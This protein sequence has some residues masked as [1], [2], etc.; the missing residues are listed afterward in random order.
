MTSTGLTRRVRRTRTTTSRASTASMLRRAARRSSRPSVRLTTCG[1]CSPVTAAASIAVA[2]ETNRPPNPGVKDERQLSVGRPQ[3]QLAGD[4]FVERVPGVQRG[5]G[6]V[7]RRAADGGVAGLD[8]D[9]A[10]R[11][12]AVASGLIGLAYGAAG[13]F[14]GGEVNE[15]IIEMENAFLFVTG[16]SD[17]SC[18]AVVSARPATSGW[19][20]T[21]WPC[22]SSGPAPCSRPS[23]GPSCRERSFG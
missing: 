20:A 7:V 21:R 3:H 13:R 1:R 12:A 16:I 19:S 5:R 2:S 15:V 23:C 11:F 6:R 10:D 9:A 18:L 22:W 8:R 17:G 14:G 4:N